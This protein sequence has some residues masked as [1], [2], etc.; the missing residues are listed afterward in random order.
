[1]GEYYIA[2]NH[3]K[4]ERMHP[5]KFGSGLKFKEFTQS[6][7][8]FVAAFAWMMRKVKPTK[9]FPAVGRWAGD[10]VELLGDEIFPGPYDEAMA[11][12]KDVSFEIFKD[13]IVDPY[14]ERS[15]EDAV[16]WRR[17]P[18]SLSC[19]LDPEEKEFYDECFGP[20]EPKSKP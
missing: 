11:E 15:L 10:N 12:Y 17:R 2:V 13:M 9:A 16:D 18:S 8:G 4:R 1:M 6:A 5:H 14:I 3:T 19:M 7:G 20:W